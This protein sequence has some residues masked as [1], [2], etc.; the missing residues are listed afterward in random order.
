M[1]SVHEQ[2]PAR[3][4]EESPFTS[5]QMRCIVGSKL[6]WG[7]ESADSGEFLGKPTDYSDLRMYGPGL[8]VESKRVAE[9]RGVMKH[10]IHAEIDREVGAWQR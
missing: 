2:N 4:V 8:A 6:M 5:A 9:R 7:Q 1:G 10:M 3:Q